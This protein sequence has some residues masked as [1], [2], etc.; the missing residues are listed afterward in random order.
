MGK[1][2]NSPNES[3]Q[4]GGTYSPSKSAPDEIKNSLFLLIIREVSVMPQGVKV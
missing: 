3:Y 1:R 4:G 2:G